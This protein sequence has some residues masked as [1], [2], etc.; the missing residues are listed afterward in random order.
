MMPQDNAYGQWSASG[1]I[2]IFESRNNFTEVVNNLHYGAWD[3]QAT[4]KWVCG[5]GGGRYICAVMLPALVISTRGD[6]L[7]LVPPAAGVCCRRH[8]HPLSAL[9]GSF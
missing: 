2:D 4:A 5:W 6:K 9:A 1:E 8:G 7:V 3:M